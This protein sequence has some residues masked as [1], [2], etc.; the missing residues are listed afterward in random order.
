M[1]EETRT[2]LKTYFETNDIP[3]QEQFYALLDSYIH[4]LDD[5]LTI[6]KPG[7]GPHRLGIGVLTPVSPLAMKGGSDTGDKMITFINAAGTAEWDISLHPASTSAN[8]FSIDEKLLGSDTPR[9]FI[10]QGTGNA[11]LGTVTPAERLQITDAQMGGHVGLSLENQAAAS[12]SKNWTIAHLQDNIEPTR[13]GALTIIEAVDTDLFERMLITK[14]GK[15]GIS[16]PVPGSILHVS[17]NPSEIGAASSLQFGSGILMLGP[18]SE[19]VIMDM[20]SIQA[21][22]QN[23]ATPPVTLSATLTLQP[24]G[25]DIN[26]HDAG[27]AT[28]AIYTNDGKFGLN[29]DPQETM[30]IAGGLRLEEAPTGNNA[31]T[32]KYEDDDFFGYTDASGWVSLTGNTSGAGAF[33][34]ASE[35]GPHSI[36]YSFADAKVGIGVDDPLSALDVIDKSTYDERDGIALHIRPSSR[37]TPTSNG[38]WRRVGLKVESSNQWSSVNT[39]QT[40]GVHVAAAQ[41][42]SALPNALLSGVFEGNMVIGKPNLNV[43]GTGGN[44]VLAIQPSPS[45]E[46]G[47]PTT[48][49]SGSATG[50]IQMY[51]KNFAI[52]SVN[53]SVLHL[54]NGDNNVIKLYRQAALP[55]PNNSTLSLTDQSLNNAVIT[56]MRSRIAGLE[57]ALRNMGL[58]PSSSNS[59]SQ[60]SNNNP[61]PQA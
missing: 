10:E 31:G 34:T 14:E 50:G 1:A 9:L 4:K 51:A 36:R 46:G 3:T 8:G 33:W 7:V 53:T 28:F 56:N 40:I 48:P 32:I 5:G 19:N 41:N 38:G 13:D 30:H 39:T 59:Q 2:Q 47:E 57:Q 37:E 42:T 43:V 35:E 29:I 17:R 11:G 27:G 16:E 61:S 23:S 22:A 52:N 18:E 58:L 44:Y 12:S 60:S 20:N 21:R 45:S 55:A 6:Y 15:V 25:G 49:A 54:R 24:L 26:F